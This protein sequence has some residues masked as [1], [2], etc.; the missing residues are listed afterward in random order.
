[1]FLQFHC[2]AIKLPQVKPDHFMAHQN[3]VNY[4][5]NTCWKECV[6]ACLCVSEYKML[7][8]NGAEITTSVSVL[9]D[10]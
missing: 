6:E 5:S 3:T 4:S 2:G 9:P 1:M 10:L 8:Q 7:I